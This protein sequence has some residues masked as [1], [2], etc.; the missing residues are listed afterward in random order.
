MDFEKIKPAVEEIALDDI[1]KARIL[2]AC[3]KQKRKFNFKPIVG[4]AAAAAVITLV[5]ASPGFLFRASKADDE[6]L[7][8]LKNET[9]FYVQ[10]LPDGKTDKKTSEIQQKLIMKI[11][12]YQ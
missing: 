8:N 5:L 4:I 2:N 1:Q 7:E 3:K 10:K 6:A 11:L 9:P 12:N